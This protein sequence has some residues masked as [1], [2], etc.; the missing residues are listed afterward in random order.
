LRA[1]ADPN[2]KNDILGTPIFEACLKGNLPIV[3]ALV[4][5]GA[6]L[7]VID[8]YGEK[9]LTYAQTRGRKDVVAFLKAEMKIEVSD[10]ELTVYVKTLLGRVIPVAVLPETTVLEIK[11]KGSVKGLLSIFCG[12]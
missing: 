4:S 1:G 2:I 3:K 11:K 9:P 6:W 8:A 5:A 7:N 12:T 10:R